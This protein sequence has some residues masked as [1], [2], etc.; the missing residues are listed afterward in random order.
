MVQRAKKYAESNTR[1]VLQILASVGVKFQKRSG[2]S[3]FN[4]ENKLS[5]MCKKW[6]PFCRVCKYYTGGGGGFTKTMI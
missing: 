6:S 1:E 3:D 4:L 5:V 2:F